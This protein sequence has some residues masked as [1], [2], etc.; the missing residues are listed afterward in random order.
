MSVGMN[1]SYL[2]NLDFQMTVNHDGVSISHGGVGGSADREF[3]RQVGFASGAAMA[4]LLDGRG[5]GAGERISALDGLP[6]LRR[7]ERVTIRGEAAP[8]PYDPVI[9]TAKE[10]TK[11]DV[12]LPDAPVPVVSPLLSASG[13]EPAERKFDLPPQEIIDAKTIVVR[14][15]PIMPDGT[16]LEPVERKMI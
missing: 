4:E 2:T 12:P 5:A 11:Q 7:G 13:A 9:L 10:I 3:A 6:G 1:P 8:V 15:T 16:P 14:E